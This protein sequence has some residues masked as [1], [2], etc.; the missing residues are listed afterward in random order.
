MPNESTRIHPEL[1]AEAPATLSTILARTR[2]TIE[3]LVP[4]GTELERAAEQAPRPPLWAS[5]FAG[6]DVAV[7]AEVKRRSP[8]RGAIA[9]G[10]VPARHAAAYRR[11]G[12][13]AISVLTE[14]AHFGGSLEDLAEVRRAVD[15]PVLRKDFILDP[16]QIFESRVAGASAVLLIARALSATVL[17][18]LA[19]LAHDVGLGVLIEVHRVAEL[20]SALRAEPDSL[21]V[22]SRDLETFR[23]DFG[24][25]ETLLKKIPANMIAVAESGIH[26]RTDVERAA[27]WGADAILVG[28]AV[29]GASDPGEAVRQLTGCPKRTAVRGRE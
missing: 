26:G 1:Q 8:S 7:I 15:L 11:G 18:D 2:Q 21:G 9:E 16:I 28:T 13:R 27:S 24:A 14:S 22:N 20:D 29:A 3:L 23:I 25:V 5:A 12:A 17:R 10:L 6:P 4:R 19:R